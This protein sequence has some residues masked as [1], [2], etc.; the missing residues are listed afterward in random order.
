MQLLKRYRKASEEQRTRL[1]RELAGALVDAREHF[2]R[3]D[4]SP[5]W[6][7]RSYP[8]RVFVREAYTDAG[9]PKD[10]Q[11]TV[12]AAVRYHV[13]A[14]LRERLDDDTLADYD[15]IPR[16]PRERSQDRR[17]SRSALLSAL[18]ARDLDG[19]ALLALTTAYTL[20]A[21]VEP[22]GLDGLDERTADV[23]AATLAD[24]ARRVNALQ[25]R[26]A[27]R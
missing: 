11:P 10:E 24:L 19:G 8:Y 3:P 5:D 22:K 26:L 12:Q 17:E 16:S 27:A 1:L 18:T 13:G 15:L 20:V 2:Q 7:G 23:V 25:D 14:V 9:I 6:K 4:G 21:R